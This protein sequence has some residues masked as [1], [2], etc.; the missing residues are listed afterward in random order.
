[1]HP[2]DEL[3]CGRTRRHG[4]ARDSG[5]SQGVIVMRARVVS[6]FVLGL[7]VGAAA[8]GTALWSPGSLQTPYMPPWKRPPAPQTAPAPATGDTSASATLQPAPVPP[9]ETPGSPQG[10]ADRSAPE[11]PST[12]DLRLGTPIV[13]VDPH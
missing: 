10:S 7:A 13:G 11:A 1:M 8:I 3:G 6:A 5:A 4:Q 2:A 9:P 12:P